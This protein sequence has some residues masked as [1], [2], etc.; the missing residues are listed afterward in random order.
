MKVA[1]IGAGNM[2]SAIAGGLAQG[3]FISTEQITVSNPSNEK[4]ER[5]KA[6]Y[7]T[8]HI[9]NNN[10]EAAMQA[11]LIIVAV[12]PWLVESVIRPLKL[13]KPQLLVSLAAGVSFEQLAHYANSELT[14]FRV[15]PN[16]AIEQQASMTVIA[17]RNAS[18]EQQ[19]TI[20]SIFSEMGRAMMLPENQMEAATALAS[21]G[22][23][24]V[25][26][27]VQAAMQAGV[28]SGLRPHE[29]MTL[30]AQSL[31]GAAQIL[32]N[33]ST[34]PSLEIDKI[35][36]PGGLTIKGLNALEHEGFTSAVIKA[37][38]AAQ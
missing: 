32:L 30:V 34:H 23:A 14:M 21:C 15:I 7:P 38:K 33:T 6:S 27:Y 22:L 18:T 26:K 37:M 17:E 28:E 8:I 4:L 12:K 13:K 5:L 36:T 29:A 3:Q 20:L 9:T 10:V 24:Y 1:I 16:T 35:T 25:M 31:E 11:D 2:G 19:Q